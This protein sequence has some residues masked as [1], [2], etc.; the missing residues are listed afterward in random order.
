MRCGFVCVE[1]FETRERRFG[2][3]KP[4]LSLHELKI[5]GLTLIV[6][7]LRCLLCRQSQLRLT[8]KKGIMVF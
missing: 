5:E 3:C 2:G 1:I 8:L 6:R 7:F 4:V